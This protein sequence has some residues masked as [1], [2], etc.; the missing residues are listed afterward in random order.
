MQL[1]EILQL[2]IVQAN[3][4]G[5]EYIT[6]ELL[7]W[8]L[9]QDED[10]SSVLAVLDIDSGE[11]SKEL[12]WY[13]Q[14]DPAI[15]RI[16]KEQMQQL[17]KE[18]QIEQQYFK[19]LGIYFRP[20]LTDGA[21]WV[22]EQALMHVHAAGKQDVLAIH[23]L[24]PMW[25]VEE[26]FATYLLNKYDVDADEYL[27]LIA[28]GMDVAENLNETSEQSEF[29]INI[30]KLVSQG[31]IAPL[32]GR[33]QE[34]QRI[35]QILARK[36]KNNPLLVG[37]AGVGKTALA[38][39]VAQAIEHQ[40][41]PEMFYDYEVLSLDISAIMAGTKYRGE[42]EKRLKRVFQE[43]QNSQ[44]PTILFIDELHTVMGLGATGEGHLDFA[45]ILK[46][47][48]EFSEIRIMGSTTYDE[49]RKFIEKD[50]AFARRFHKVDVEEPSAED[51]LK[52]LHGVKSIFEDYHQVKYRNDILKLTVELAENY[53]RD[54]RFP[55]KAIDIIDEVGAS[56]RIK[57]SGKRPV[58]VKKRELEQVVA[59]M[60]K[61]PPK[62]LEK[63][64]KEKVLEIK[65]QLE[66][67]LFGQGTAIE[68]VGDAIILAKSP[69]ADREKPIA[70]FLF[71]GPTGVGKTELAK[72][73]AQILSIG[74]IRFDMSEYMEKHSVAKLIGSPPGYVGHDEGGLLTD[75]VKQTP[76]AVLLLD[77]I[78]KAHSDIFNIL[79]QI[80]DYGVLTDAKG[81]KT[82]FKNVILI[83]TSNVGAKALGERLIGL[84]GNSSIEFKRDKK[85]KRV[86]T[87]EFRN[88]LTAI[89]NFSS[90]GHDALLKVVGKNVQ[91]L[92]ERLQ[93]VG[94]ALELCDRVMEYILEE[95]YSREYGARNI[96]RYV[97]QHVALPIAKGLLHGGDDVI[98]VEVS[99]EKEK[100]KFNFLKKT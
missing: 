100:L 84:T 48:L 24:V 13:L 64:E 94:I 29:C 75:A 42:F 54:L 9:L 74:F 95:S 63:D 78:E 50:R 2:A 52:I 1:N 15:S 88:R 77:E 92:K 98:R 31:K 22:I 73:L 44:I 49:Y 86:F 14:Q 71:V 4:L 16:S 46:P 90:L 59:Q 69:L 56:L 35:F 89:I 3:E 25:E 6:V 41:C 21:N 36:T 33:Q 34:L 91:V 7:L 82:D 47:I 65:Q 55:D 53:L 80:M 57:Q 99:V 5:H 66:Q 11:M 20:E 96:N 28:H 76:H 79:L 39:G 18:Q 60:S 23:L 12:Y 40:Q 61:I 58:S 45:N 8:V 81:R 17:G 19:T 27:E 67:V 87:P 30:S 83:M 85:I 68:Q 38:Y 26:S 72:Q 93:G 32:I 97:E 43:L 10:V 37:E 51:T 62:N 70:N